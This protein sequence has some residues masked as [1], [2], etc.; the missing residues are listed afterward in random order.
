MNFK[1]SYTPYSGETSVNDR[2]IIPESSFLSPVKIDDTVAEEVVRHPDTADNSAT[3]SFAAN[4][5]TPASNNDAMRLNL[6]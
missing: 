4:A 2:F 3:V 1:V 6:T 5:E